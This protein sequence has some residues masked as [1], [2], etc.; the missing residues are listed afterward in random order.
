MDKGSMQPMANSCSCAQKKSLHPSLNIYCTVLY[1]YS[2]CPYVKKNKKTKSSTTDFL[3]E[4]LL[5]F[6]G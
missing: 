2:P 6:V 1:I 4:R 3:T 5:C